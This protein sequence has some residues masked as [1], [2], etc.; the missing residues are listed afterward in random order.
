MAGELKSNL[1]N[2]RTWLRGLL[3][4]LFA[5]LYGVAEFVV[6]VLVVVQFG[7][8]LITGEPMPRLLTFA[9]G[10]NAYVFQILEFITYR[11]DERPFPFGA[12]PSDGVSAGAE[13]ERRPVPELGERS[14]VERVER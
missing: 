10:L 13:T 3:I 7:S 1:T 11:R 9:R 14:V 2:G 12:W 5:I 6:T 4:I 8:H